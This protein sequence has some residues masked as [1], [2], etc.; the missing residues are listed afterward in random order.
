M[1][2]KSGGTEAADRVAD[3]LLLFVSG[4]PSLGVSTISRELGLAKA[5]VHR[6][7]ASLA[8]RELVVADRATRE[9]RLGPAAMAIGAR[10][11]RGSDLRAAARPVLARLRD[12]TRETTT[13]S[14][15]VGDTRIYLDQFES[16]QEIKMLVEIGRAFPLHAGSSSKAILAFLPE[17]RREAILR[18]RLERLTPQTICD[19]DRLRA[20]LA[21][22]AREGVAVSRGERQHGAGSVAA[23]VFDVDGDVRGAISICGPIDRFW[24]SEVERF[25]PMVRAAA[26]EI[27]R[28]LG[29]Q[30]QQTTATGGRR[31]G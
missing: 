28:A 11:L 5:V 13:L 6:I 31:R 23:P 12:E 20:V 2:K 18:G 30:P 26:Q 21:E 25:V 17:A 15:L 1:E 22:I 19:P 8:S 9:Y 10:A 14:Q 27:S 24:P 16:P 7:L 3:V 4:P 29:W